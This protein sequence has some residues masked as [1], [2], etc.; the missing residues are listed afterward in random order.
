MTIAITGA[1][2]HLG[3]LTAD[4]VLD[5]VNPSELILVTR[6][7]DTLAAYADRGVQV[8][9]GDFADADSLREAF[10]G[11]AKLLLISLDKIGERVPLQ[12]A[13]IGAAAAAGVRSVAYTSIVNPSHSNPAA[14]APDHRAT[15]EALRVSGLAWTFLRNSIYADM[16]LRGAEPALASGALVTNEGEGRVS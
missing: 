11:A 5:R 12:L 14:A 6:S 4:A 16:L 3:R 9:Q 10:A 7:P 8:R 13:A 1:S 15:E 2:G